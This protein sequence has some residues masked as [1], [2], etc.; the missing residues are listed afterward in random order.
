MQGSLDAVVGSELGFLQYPT[1]ALPASRL[2]NP[3]AA[4]APAAGQ[5][6]MG[7]LVGAL[8]SVR[9]ASLG[10]LHLHSHGLVH[11]GLAPS[12][13]LLAEGTPDGRGF[14]V[15]VADPGLVTVRRVAAAARA[16]T[17][18][19][20]GESVGEGGSEGEGA[21]SSPHKHTT[22]QS[23]LALDLA[24]EVLR[25]SP[26]PLVPEAVQSRS[27]SRFSLDGEDGF[28]AA[29]GPEC[30]GVP[31]SKARCVGRSLRFTA[32]EVVAG[33][34]PT[35]AGDVYSLGALLYYALYAQQPYQALADGEWKNGNRVGVGEDAVMSALAFGP[36]LTS[37]KC[38]A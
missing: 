1:P 14:I 31:M 30:K 34:E 24:S 38:G 19:D 6:P 12:N 13:L 20:E 8:R 23:A 21:D 15:K 22:T 9:E 26:P 36:C 32:P 27:A 28:S 5:G 16:T 17:N 33:C 35:A 37:K 25:T 18:L 4:A 10:L 7:Q 3:R 11:G 29:A 2:G